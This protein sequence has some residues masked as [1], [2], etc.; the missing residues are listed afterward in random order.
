MM[1]RDGVAVEIEEGNVDWRPVGRVYKANKWHAAGHNVTAVVG[2]GVLALPH[3]LK[4]IT[5]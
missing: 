2:A 1:Q 3:V 5:L 4:V